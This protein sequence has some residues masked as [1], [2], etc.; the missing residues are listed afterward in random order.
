[1]SQ[2]PSAARLIAAHR[3]T[4]NG[5]LELE[6]RW[7]M[8]AVGLLVI[9]LLM[10]MYFKQASQARS[11]LR[12]Q[13]AA[14]QTAAVWASALAACGSPSAS[15][16][17]AGHG[18]AVSADGDTKL[19]WDVLHTLMLARVKEG[20]G[21]THGVPWTRVVDMDGNIYAD[22]GAGPLSTEGTL[23][24]GNMSHW[25]TVDSSD[26]EHS[27]LKRWSMAADAGGAVVAYTVEVPESGLHK[28]QI[29]AVA[30]VAG[31]RWMVVVRCE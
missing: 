18:A 19:L 9:G 15:A 27:V 10:M 17:W 29:V 16:V 12:M 13:F 14:R 5:T 26:V 22:N 1:M 8:A 11:R 7:V 28:R 6:L 21:G 4:S 30:P 20:V 23:P 25:R 31:S 3:A 24:M 2:S